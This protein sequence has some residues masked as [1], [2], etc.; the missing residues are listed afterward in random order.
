MIKSTLQDHKKAISDI[1]TIFTFTEI[2]TKRRLPNVNSASG[3][4]SQKSNLDSTRSSWVDFLKRKSYSGNL[5]PRQVTP[6]TRD[7]FEKVEE[8]AKK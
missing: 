8:K 6:S 5:S 1:R 4:R 7:F 3:F 2:D